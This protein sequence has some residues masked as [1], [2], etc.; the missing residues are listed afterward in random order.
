MEACGLAA[1]PNLW[2]TPMCVGE[3]ASKSWKLMKP[4]DFFS[5]VVPFKMM[6]ETEVGI[7]V[8][9]DASLRFQ[10]LLIV[11]RKPAS[12]SHLLT[13]KHWRSVIGEL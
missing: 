6:E 11:L 12:P 10:F 4:E 5:M 8:L 9:S 7:V 3:G 2:H 1:T 13:T